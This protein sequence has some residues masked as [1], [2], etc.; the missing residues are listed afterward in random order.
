MWSIGNEIPHREKPE[1]A[2]I[3]KKLSSYI[4]QLDSTKAITSGVNGIDKDKDDFISALDVAGYNYAFDKYESDHQRL[5]SRIMV[6]TESF[7]LDAF[8]YWMAVKDHTYVIGDFVWTAFD[9]MGEASIGWRCSPQTQE[10]YP[11]HLAYCGDINICGWK[12][13]QS[14]YRDALWK[15]NQVSVFVEPPT[16]SLP[17]N[18][19]KPGWCQWNWNDVVADWNWKGYEDKIFN[20]VVYSSCDEV[21]L[22]LNGKSLGKKQTNRS[23]KFI[24]TYQVPY[25][26]GELKV[27]GYTN[28]K[29]MQQSVLQTAGEPTNLILTPDKKILHANNQGLVYINV[30]LT[31]DKGIVNQKTD[32]PVQFN[33]EGAGTIAGVGNANPVSEESYQSNKRKTW[34]GKCLLIVKAGKEKG[35]IKISAAAGNIQS[36][37]LVIKVE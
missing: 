37:E 3:A 12:R 4:K 25:A 34:R 23:T 35:D 28:N 31:D 19:D 29:K 30:E 7:P 20:V 36:K 8:D 24:A 26:A 21:E 16:P 6:A 22:F 17:L 15:E 32:L 18:K 9:Y 13:P 27:V 2:A 14:F 5:P 33:V 11:W 10:F 1:V